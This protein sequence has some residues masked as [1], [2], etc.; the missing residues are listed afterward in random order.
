MPTGDELTAVVTKLD[1]TLFDAYNS[2]DLVSFARYVAP[3]IEFYHDKGGFEPG[4]QKLVQS[5]KNNICGKLRRV[6]I[7]G[8]LEIYPIPG[9]GALETGAD[10]FCVLQ[11][12]NCDAYSKF[13]QLWKYQNG[14]WLLTRVFSYDHRI[15]PP[16][17]DPATSV[18]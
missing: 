18:P 10:R 14:T 5:I 4:R 2:C 16:T 8:T 12:G 3:D 7:P 13:S 11:T 9:Y 15:L 1:A 6:L 17:G